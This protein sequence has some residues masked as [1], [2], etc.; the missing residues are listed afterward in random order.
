MGVNSPITFIDIGASKGEF[1]TALCKFYDVKKGVLIEPIIHNIDKLKEKFNDT[2]K[3]D[4]INVAVS[5]KT[6]QSE[7]FLSEDFDVLSSL[8]KIK[9]DHLSPFAISAPIKIIVNTETLDNIAKN[10]MLDIVDLIKIDVQGAE[11]LVLNSGLNI[12]KST[13]MVYTEFSYKPMYDSSSTFFDVFNILADNNF[14]MVNIS[15][16]YKLKNGEIVQGDAL[17]INNVFL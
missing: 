9:D 7:F 1:S 6:G 11:H 2:S 15:T 10:S 3:F 14:R 12:L 8:F 17:F 4:I 5:D 13:K 16:A